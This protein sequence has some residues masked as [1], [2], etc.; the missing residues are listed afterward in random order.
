MTTAQHMW[1]VLSC[2]SCQQ[3]PLVTGD[4]LSVEQCVQLV[5]SPILRHR[6]SQ[7]D[8]KVCLVTQPVWWP[9]ACGIVQPCCLCTGKRSANPGLQVIHSNKSVA[10]FHLTHCLPD[11][12]NNYLEMVR[13]QKFVKFCYPAV[14][15]N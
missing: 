12:I 6:Y 14:L 10:G 1:V 11:C 8:N 15:D 2:P 5:Y 9:C 4:Y 13:Q 7:S 3:W